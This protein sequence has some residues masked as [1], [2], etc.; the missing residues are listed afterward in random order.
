M[1]NSVTTKAEPAPDG[2]EANM[3]GPAEGAIAAAPP[4]APLPPPL[5]LNDL[6]KL[7]TDRLEAVAR[8]ID[9]RL[10][11]GRTRHYHILDVVRASLGRGGAV[12]A[13]GFLDEQAE[14]GPVLRSAALNFLPVPEDVSVPRS[15]I[16]KY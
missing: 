3:P 8:E 11:P 12:S 14:G 7:S 4:P 16:Q 13:Q 5:H 9:L 15:L 10:F 1:D 6:Q 2:G